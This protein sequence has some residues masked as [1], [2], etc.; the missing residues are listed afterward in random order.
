MTDAAPRRME[1]LS[2][3]ESLRLLGSVSFGRIAFSL[4]ALPAIRPVNHLVDGGD[5][6]IRSHSD[7]GMT[8]AA[9][10]VVAYE[11]DRIGEE[12]H[13]GWS[14]II[15]G[16]AELVRDVEQLA[17]YEGRLRPWVAVEMDAV[18]RIPPEFV[19]GYRLVNGTP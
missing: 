3:E 9:G 19:T 12:D 14:V 16:K 2:T 18:I 8:N 7:S 13:L 1:Q 10:Q 15:T 11:A 6:I 4:H 5:V 17:R